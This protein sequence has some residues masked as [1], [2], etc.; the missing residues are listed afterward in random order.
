[1]AINLSRN[2]KVFF[3]TN[4]DPVKGTV[5]AAGFTPN[6]TFELQVL[7]GFS[8]SQTT[9]A[10]TVTVS[11]S[12]STPSRGQRSFN[13]S[14]AP[15]DFSFSTY[16]RPYNNAV[17]SRI[18]AEES[19]LWNAL[20]GSKNIQVP[21][22]V[23]LGTGGTGTVSSVAYA[24]A[25]SKVT[26][27][28]T[29]LPTT[30]LA[31]GDTVVLSGIGSSVSSSSYFNNLAT[32]D[33]GFTAT[34]WV[35]TL[36]N[37]PGNVANTL[38]G[39]TITVTKVTTPAAS[40]TQVIGTGGTGTITGAAYAYANGVATLTLTGTTLPI[41]APGT[42]YTLNG[43][44]TTAPSTS[45]PAG[46]TTANSNPDLSTA[47]Y[48]AVAGDSV[49]GS[50]KLT[51]VTP[52]TA[53]TSIT[54]ATPTTINLATS[55]WNEIS[56]AAT[57]SS[58]NSDQ[59]QLQK[60]GMLFLVDNVLYSI[61]NCAINQVTIDYGLDQITT[62][63]WT[64]QGT[65]L[66]R[67]TTDIAVAASAT[68][69][70]GNVKANYF[71]SAST[72]TNFGGAY[73]LKNVDAKY[74]T[75]KLSTVDLTTVNA[76]K[77]SSGTTNI[78]ANT[79]FTV[80]ITGGSLTITNNISYLTPTNLNT[81]NKPAANF[82]G[83]R[84]ISGSITAYLKTGGS[85]DTGTLLKGILDSASASTEPMFKYDMFIG[86]G[87]APYVQVTMPT[88]FLQVPTVDVQQLVSTSIGFTAEGSSGATTGFDVTKTNEILVKY[89]A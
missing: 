31:A 44:S 49:A 60:F 46:A 45:T 56:T 69:L 79:K 54:L 14:L 47:V 77:D 89:V 83:T 5:N 10:D 12:G 82:V 30:G 32:L 17:T 8:F 43:L 3:T 52:F 78:A 76:I 23:I 13:S 24:G 74:I 38:S 65:T 70:A 21:T 25:T 1:M 51:Y 85:N 72:L 58:A 7:D 84:A 66:N 59:N 20:L 36:L 63:Q 16:I 40:I 67:V 48:V 86:G 18:T 19:V 4:I 88:V 22:T 80:A 29:S 64:G 35:F 26:V 34:S 57:V 75:N 87:T 42:I 11:E 9:A 37:G 50:L 53:Y 2:S 81:V 15:A 28:G 55:S 33:A 6:N 39:S 27:T 71:L 61:D 68:I 41:I 62:A 73:L